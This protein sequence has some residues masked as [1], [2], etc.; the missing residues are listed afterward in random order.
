MSHKLTN[1]KAQRLAAGY[2]IGDLAK[3]AGVSDRAIIVAENGGAI[4]V[5]ESDRI[6][7]ALAVSL[8]T[9]GKVDY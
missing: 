4:H 1:M 6:A 7:T 5:N 3:R 9:L 2:S 8:A